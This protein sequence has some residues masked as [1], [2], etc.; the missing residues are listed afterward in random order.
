MRQRQGEFPPKMPTRTKSFLQRKKRKG[1]LL[2]R[3]NTGRQI[4]TAAESSRTGFQV[5]IG[6]ASSSPQ[7]LV[8]VLSEQI[9]IEKQIQRISSGST[10]V[11]NEAPYAAIETAYREL[12]SD[13][14]HALEIAPL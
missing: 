1:R 8:G 4:G 11:N 12:E 5:R 14:L 3:G 7:D 10:A 2:E 9:S 6:G 13:L